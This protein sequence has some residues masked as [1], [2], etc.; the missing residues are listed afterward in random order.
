MP[1]EKPIRL[2][3]E[4]HEPFGME[5]SVKLAPN[6][7]DDKRYL[8]SVGRASFGPD[9]IR[10]LSRMLDQLGLPGHFAERL[11]GSLQGADVIHF[12][13]ESP[14]GCDVYKVYFEYASAV[15]KAM[16]ARTSGEV[17]VHVAYKWTPSQ[18]GRHAVTRYSWVPCRDTLELRAKIEDL[19]SATEAPVGQ[20]CVFDVLSRIRPF[21]DRGELLLMK[22]E[23]PGNSRRSC[24]LNVYDAGLQ[25]HQVVDVFGEVA[26]E[27]SIPADVV[28]PI[29][30]R[31]GDRALGHLSAGAGRDGREF[32]TVYF[33]VEAH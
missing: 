31:A 22:V 27:F 2:V 6:A 12:G 3:E 29:F 15:R 26:K 23:E 7:I 25:V 10:R 30:D 11:P 19:V 13:Y 4:L 33:G 14:D 28:Q 1:A 5:R 9:P 18:P 8:L 32:V 16:A 17:L 24:D 20:R 21:A